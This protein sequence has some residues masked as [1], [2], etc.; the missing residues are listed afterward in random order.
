MPLQSAH[1]KP[2]L[3][4]WIATMFVPL[5]RPL[6]VPVYFAL[7]SEQLANDGPWLSEIGVP[8]FTLI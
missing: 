7:L 4:K 1:E 3:Q 5:F 6:N 2:V 8:L